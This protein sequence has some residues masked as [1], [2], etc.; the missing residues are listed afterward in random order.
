LGGSGKAQAALHFVF[1]AARVFLMAGQHV[2]QDYREFEKK[3]QMMGE[4]GYWPQ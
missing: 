1:E 2:L 4:N 3:L